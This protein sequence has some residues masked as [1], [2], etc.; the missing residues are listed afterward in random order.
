MRGSRF[1][2]DNQMVSNIQ[3]SQDL[4]IKIGRL[5][6]ASMICVINQTTINSNKSQSVGKN[7]KI[8]RV[9]DYYN[10]EWIYET[11]DTLSAA[12]INK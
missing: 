3:T 9:P 12:N 2:D 5:Y 6:N 11:S 1:E 10:P 4:A 7:K 8:G